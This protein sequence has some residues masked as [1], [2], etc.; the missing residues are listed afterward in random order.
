MKLLNFKKMPIPEISAA[1]ASLVH[2]LATATAII[3]ALI[4]AC[5]IIVAQLTSEVQSKHSDTSI[6]NAS[7]LVS[8]AN[9]SA[10]Q[11]QAKIAALIQQNRELTAQLQ[12]EKQARLKIESRL[13]PR[14]LTAQAQAA[15]K[16]L[17]EDLAKEKAHPTVLLNIVKNDDEALAFAKQITVAL[18]KAGVRVQI[19]Q[20]MLT[21]EA[22]GTHVVVYNSA[23]SQEI[24]KAM[25][26]AEFASQ[27]SRSGQTPKIQI[28]DQDSPVISAFI[29]VYPKDVSLVAHQ[30][31]LS[32]K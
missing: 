11:S 12:A 13:Q 1:N 19:K 8:Q 29:N 2:T 4:A 23:G 18:T 25:K 6:A 22:T 3:A 17:A 9:E 31:E 5:A 16:V 27:I 15:F 20:L 24:E 32:V 30:D 10:A 7:Q 26:A 28:S 21:K 14:K